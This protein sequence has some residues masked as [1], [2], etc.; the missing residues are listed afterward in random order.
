MDGLKWQGYLYLTVPY[1]QVSLSSNKFALLHCKPLPEAPFY[2]NLTDCKHS[3]I[4]KYDWLNLGLDSFKL[5]CKKTFLDA[6]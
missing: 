4:K 2:L 6:D 1:N 3:P 5:K